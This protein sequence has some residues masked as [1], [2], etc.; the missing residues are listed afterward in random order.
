[1]HPKD[2]ILFV[3]NPV[4]GVLNKRNLDEIIEKYLKGRVS[5]RTV[6]WAHQQQSVKELIHNNITDTTSL[7]AAVGGDGTVNAVADALSGTGLVL[8]IVPGGSGNGIARHLRI[9]LRLSKALQVLVDGKTVEIDQCKI[10]DR[11]FL[12]TAGIG[13]D[14]EVARDFK[15]SKRR[16]IGNYI[17]SVL[18]IF[19]T[20]K[21]QDYHLEIDGHPLDSRAF[22]ITFANAAQ[23]GANAYIAPDAKIDDG[24][25]DIVVM[26]MPRYIDT[27]GIVFKLFYRNIYKSPLVKLYR[28]KKVR[29]RKLGKQPVHY[30]GEDYDDFDTLDIEVIHKAIKVR[31]P[32]KY[33]F[34]LWNFLM[35][36]TSRILLKKK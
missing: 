26:K 18:Q 6:F 4:A 21:P 5:Y 13:F 3:I 20:Y 16:G 22:L 35:E 25:L 11:H 10:N 1:M 30:D 9:P 12:T 8:G 19:R 32:V 2:E 29:L 7:V 14:A 15:K 33:R 27:I 36:N 34:N 23:Y 24:M 17:L 28:G 31:V